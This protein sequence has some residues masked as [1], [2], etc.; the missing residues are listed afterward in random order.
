MLLS[1][2]QLAGGHVQPG[3]QQQRLHVFGLAGEQAIQSR[4][5]QVLLA[6]SE[7]QLR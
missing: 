4:T 3:Q 7:M 5:R 2:L 6:L 1:A